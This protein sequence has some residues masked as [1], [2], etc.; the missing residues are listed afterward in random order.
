MKYTSLGTV[1]DST[2]AKL[3][4]LKLA[5]HIFSAIGLL[6]RI[7]FPYT[8]K[9]MATP[10][11]SVATAASMKRALFKLS[12]MKSCW[13]N[14]GNIPESMARRKAIGAFAEAAWLAYVSQR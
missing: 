14:N 7:C 11:Y 13:P 8:P 1:I 10:Q 9:R 4:V 2:A 3:S 6:S 5:V 12:L